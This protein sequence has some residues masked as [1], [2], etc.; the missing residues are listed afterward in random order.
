[1]SLEVF[2]S[3]GRIQME[4]CSESRFLLDGCRCV[5]KGKSKESNKPDYKLESFW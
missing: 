4:E 1:M 3:C 5:L 2:G